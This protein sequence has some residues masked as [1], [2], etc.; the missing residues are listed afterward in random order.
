MNFNISILFF[1]IFYSCVAYDA[2]MPMRKEDVETLNA[3]PLSPQQVDI[4]DN[5][6]YLLSNPEQST[7]PEVYS[8]WQELKSSLPGNTSEIIN[9]WEERRNELLEPVLN[10][11]GEIVQKTNNPQEIQVFDEFRDASTSLASG[12]NIPN[13]TLVQYASVQEQSFNHLQNYSDIYMNVLSNLSMEFSNTLSTMK[14]Q[15][16]NLKDKLDNVTST[17]RQRMNDIWDQASEAASNFRNDTAE[18]IHEEHPEVESTWGKI[19]SG[20]RDFGNKIKNGWNSFIGLFKSKPEET[21]TPSPI[22]DANANLLVWLCFRSLFKVRY[23][24]AQYFF[25]KQAA[26]IQ[27]ST[28]SSSLL[29]SAIQLARLV[30]TATGNIE[31]KKNLKN[32]IDPTMTMPKNEE[33]PMIALSSPGMTFVDFTALMCSMVSDISSVPQWELKR[34]FDIFDV[35]SDGKLSAVESDALNRV[36]IDEVNCLKC[37]LIVVDFQ[38]DFVNGSLAIKKGPAQQDPHEALVPLNRLL[39][40]TK[41]DLIVYTQDWHPPNH[42]SFYEHCRNP[43][44]SLKPEDKNRKLRP[45]DVVHFEVPKCLQVL[46]P[47]HCLQNSWGAELSP[48]LTRVPSAKFI[49]KGFNVHVDAYS[50]F[51]D[52][53]GEKKSELAMLLR[54]EGIDGL[55]ICG[56]A[57]EIC[58]AATTREAS[59]LGFLTALISDCSKGLDADKINE[60]NVELS[61]RNVAI[62]DSHVAEQFPRSRKIPWKWVCQFSG[63]TATNNDVGAITSTEIKSNGSLP[64]DGIRKAE[65]YFTKTYYRY[66]V[67]VGRNPGLFLILSLV[68]VVLALPGFAFIRINLDLYKLFVPPDAPVKTEFERQQVYNQI[69]QGDLDYIP[70]VPNYKP[71]RLPKNSGFQNFTNELFEIEVGENHERSKRAVPRHTDIL[72]FYVVHENYENLLDSE[73]LGLL[74]NYTN[75]MM[76]VHTQ[77]NG[78][79]YPFETF[80]KKEAENT[81]CTN[82]LNIWLKHAENLFKS[83]GSRTNPNLQLSYPVM[84]LFNRPKDIGN[85]IY[86]VDVQGE[87]HEI[88]GAR[89]LTLHWFINFPL[90]NDNMKAYLAFRESCNEFWEK[91]TQE[92]HI[93]FIPHNDKAM[94]DELR[95]IIEGAIPFAIPATLQLMFFVW[96]TNLSKDK[97]KSK[98]AEGYFGVVCVCLGLV[99]SFGIAFYIGVPFNPVASTMPF[100]ILAI[101]VDDAFLMLGAWRMTDPKDPLDDR[102]GKAMAD[103]GASITVTSL[104]NFGCFALGYWLSPTPAVRDFCTLTAIGMLVDYIYQMTF[105]PAILMYGA[106]RE[107]EG[108]LIAYFPCCRCKK[109]PTLE[110]LAEIQKNQDYHEPTLMH[111]LFRDKWAPFILNPKVKAVSWLLFVIYIGVSFWGCINMRVNISPHKYI[112]DTSPIQTFVYL[113]DKYIWADNVMPTFHVMAPPDFRNTTQRMRFNELIFRL[114]NTQYSIGR[115]STNLWLWEY[116]GFLND[117]PEVKYEHD[118]YNRKYLKNFFDQFDYQQFRGTVKIDDKAL[119]GEPCIKAFTFQTSFYALNSWDKRQAELFHWRDILKQFPEFDVFL[120]G[121][122]SPFLIDQRHTIAPSS[123]QTIGTAIVVMA[124]MCVFFLPNKFSIFIMCLAIITIST[125]VCG[126]LTHLGSDLDSV[127]M[128]CIVMAIG[129]AVDFS[130]HICHKYH[131]STKETPDEKVIDTLSIVGYPILQAGGSTLWA[132]TTLPLI[133]AYLVR[134]FVQTVVLVNIFGMIHALVWLPQFISALDPLIRTPKRF[135]HYGKDRTQ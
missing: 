75:E 2:L 5:M 53:N 103:A 58:V 47:A 31:Y 65:H 6:N 110:E 57:Y 76:F 50:A 15:L 132:M 87:K 70:K 101:G 117:F 1:S 91:K 52:N 126:F 8:A 26:I 29:K 44:R 123:M 104:T 18:W 60:T 77:Y 59:K 134:V 74:W 3:G 94:D 82:H 118:F 27:S 40:E 9:D 49:R 102:M 51:S 7:L 120:A 34:L 90:E 105:F 46:Y 98:P 19:K 128:G 16:G 97:R 63:V 61:E 133:P 64:Q 71:D 116:Q 125:G 106:R 113:A 72:R 56:L 100:L 95:L 122:F 129:L 67:V 32:P 28:H 43:D 112:R 119:N 96:F 54:S 121:I 12:K 83:G 73:V 135:L 42:I 38:N 10:Q 107:N 108:G 99:V 20:F 85:I 131:G 4:V 45:F 55:F 79:D 109:G 41:F 17:I 80:C 78:V 11:L 30:A 14:E 89:V 93:K 68:A 124:I 24:H 23:R 92:S 39:Q 127:S 48:H 37:A 88:T 36:I 114:E 33:Q 84:Y 111:R 115:V 86:G 62:I 81:K 69:P 66:G 25:Q 21:T 22:Y 130:V 13:I 35:D